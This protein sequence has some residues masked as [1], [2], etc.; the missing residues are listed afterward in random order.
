MPP[1]NALTLRASLR[2]MSA[3]RWLFIFTCLFT[4]RVDVTALPPA[5]NDG[6]A[7]AAAKSRGLLRR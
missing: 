4:A 7:D 6:R 2:A 1:A 3:S 5:R